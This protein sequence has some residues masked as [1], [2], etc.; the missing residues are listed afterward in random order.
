MCGDWYDWDTGKDGPVQGKFTRKV[1]FEDEL[2]SI[3][4]PG[5]VVHIFNLGTPEAEV[6]EGKSL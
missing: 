1:A 6:G 3:R 5:K 2:K 4:E